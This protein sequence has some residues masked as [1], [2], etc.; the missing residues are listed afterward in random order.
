MFPARL[1]SR[2]GYQNSSYFQ[3]LHLRHFTFIVISKTCNEQLY[4]LSV[5]TLMRGNLKLWHAHMPVQI[6]DTSPAL[7]TI[8]ERKYVPILWW[9]A[10]CVPRIF[11]FTASVSPVSCWAICIT[12]FNVI[13]DSS[14]TS[15]STF[16]EIRVSHWTL[17]PHSKC[18]IMAYALLLYYLC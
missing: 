1:H 13:H 5:S 3:V 4:F 7:W 2:V 14:Y 9:F 12:L 10:R 15:R 6:H 17:T 16:T 11:R 18:F 8:N